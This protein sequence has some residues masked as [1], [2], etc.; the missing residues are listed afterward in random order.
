MTLRHSDETGGANATDEGCV[1]AESEQRATVL[2]VLNDDAC[3]AILSA[4][5]APLTAK[6][7]A[8]SCDLPLSTVYR[9]LERIVSTPLME[10]TT[11][12][13]LHGKHPQQFQRRTDRV[14]VRIPSDHPFDVE[15]RARVT[16]QP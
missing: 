7:L 11:R 10:E 4:A 12:V 13:R 3:R 6:E 9:K 15:V 16:D 8:R 5:D 14:V 2:S 1:E